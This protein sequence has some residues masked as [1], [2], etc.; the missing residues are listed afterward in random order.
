[1]TL[2]YSVESQAMNMQ[3]TDR[4]NIAAGIRQSGGIFSTLKF[5]LKIIISALSP[6]QKE[7][8]QR[9]LSKIAS[10]RGE[11]RRNQGRNVP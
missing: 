10:H 7:P 3:T 5:S 9:P 6:S 2:A 8:P 11:N 1:M 4:A